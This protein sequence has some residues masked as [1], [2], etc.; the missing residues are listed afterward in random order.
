VSLMRWLGIGL[1]LAGT[2]LLVKPVARAEQAL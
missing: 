1:I 2:T